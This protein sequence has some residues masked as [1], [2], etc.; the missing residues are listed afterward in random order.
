MSASVYKENDVLKVIQSHEQTRY[1]V[2]SLQDLG[3][4]AQGNI[5]NL[6]KL[7]KAPFFLWA[8]VSASVDSR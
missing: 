8:S 2:W 5:H 3:L 7:G 1:S 6:N 4:R